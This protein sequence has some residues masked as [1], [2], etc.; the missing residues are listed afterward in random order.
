MAKQKTK[1]K[2]KAI[3]IEGP[4]EQAKAEL[5][6][7]KQNEAYEA[8]KK[9]RNFFVFLDLIA[10]IFLILAIYLLYQGKLIKGILTLLV[11]VLIFVYFILRKRLNKKEKK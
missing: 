4:T 6:I 1:A 3:K 2:K 8:R 11:T 10:L 7:M 5:M 9:K